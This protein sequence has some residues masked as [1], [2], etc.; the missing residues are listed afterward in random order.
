MS[1]R[2]V[3]PPAE[4]RQPLTLILVVED[5]EANAE[6]LKEALTF[7]LSCVVHQVSNGILAL[8]AVEAIKPNLIVLDYLL[9]VMD[10]LE[11]YD[12]L[13]RMP[14]LS[15]IPV[16]FLSASSNQNE[17]EHRHLPFLEKPFELETLLERV[18]Y[19]LAQ[20]RYGKENDQGEPEER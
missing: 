10:G 13:Q 20:G 15:R 6:V 7:E 16:L 14:G 2:Y 3:V 9:P 8:R 17:I 18:R 1:D 11:L 4:Q 5:D 19:L 12:R